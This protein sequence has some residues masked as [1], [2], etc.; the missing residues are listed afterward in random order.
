MID[1]RWD[2][3]VTG[4]RPSATASKSSALRSSSPIGRVVVSQRKQ[5]DLLGDA[6]IGDTPQANSDREQFQDSFKPEQDWKPDYTV[7]PERP[8][9]EYNWA[10]SGTHVSVSNDEHDYQFSAMGWND[11]SRPHAYGKVELHYKWEVWWH[12]Y[13]TNMSL[14]MVESRLRRYTRD[15]G[16][17]WGG[18]LD[19]EGVPMESRALKQASVEGIGEINPGLKDWKNNE[20]AGMEMFDNPAE[21]QTD[22]PFYG[23]SD[24]DD[25][26]MSPDDA[27]T[28]DECGA[29]MLNYDDWRKHV[30]RFHVNPDRKPPREPQPVVDLDDVLPANFNEAI[31]DKTV[32]RQSRLIFQL[33]AS[34]SRP[35]QIPGP[36]P[37]IYDIESDRIYVGH[38]GERHSDIKGR[39]TPGG[40]I[41][42]V[43][44]PKGSV[45]IRT[46]TDMPYT[47]RHMAELWYAM[48]PELQIKSIYLLVGEKRFKLASSNIGHKVR[49]IAASDPAAWAAFKALE[50]LGN[51]YVVGGAVRDIVRGQTPKDVDLM[52]QG[53][54]AEDV[55]D[56]LKG[57]PGRVDFTG[58]QF[59]VF[60]YRDREGNEV[61]IALPRTERSTGPGH[62]DFE[63]ATDPY[64]SVGQD[65][66]RRDFTGNAMAV[67]LATGD[68]V[69]PYHGSEDLKSGVLRTVSDRSFLEDPL[70]ILR[71]FGSVSRH[72]L[73][74]SPDTY[75]DLAA[76][77]HL[78]GEL[79]KER[80]Q[81]ELD[82][83]MGGD[84][85]AK[86]ID[87]MEATGVLQHA[88][89]EVA[90]T[91]GF[92][93]KSKYHAHLLSDHIKLVLRLTA[94]Q[95]KDVDVRWAALLHD[96][97]KP[98][99]QWFDDEGYG[100]YYLNEKGE[101]HDHETLGAEMAEKLLT[102]LR[103][104]NDRIARIVHLV[105]H[106]MFPPFSAPNGARKFLNKVGD[107][108]ADDLM[109]IR[110]ADSGGKDS[111]NPQDGSV[112]QMTQLIDNVR[113]AREPTN[114]AALAINGNDLI[115][116][117]HKPG[118]QMGALLKHLVDL[119]L[120][121]PSLNNRETLLQLASQ[122]AVPAENAVPATSPREA[123]L[124]KTADLIDSLARQSDRAL[125]EAYGYGTAKPGEYGWECNVASAR[126]VLKLMEKGVTDIEKLADESHEGWAEA[127]RQWKD[128]GEKRE[129]RMKLADTPY[130]DL[131]E[132][133]KEKDRVAAR[134]LLDY[135]RSNVLNEK[136]SNILD[137]IKDELDP[138]VFNQPDAMAPTVKPKIVNWVKNKIY[139]TM[140][141][142]GWPDPS[143]YLSL[144]LTGSLTTYQWSAESDFDT[145]LWID[146]ER[147]PEWVRADLIALMI[148]QCDGTI[149]PGTTHPIQCFVVDSTRFTKQDLYEP[150]L[151]SGYDLDKGDWLVMPEKDRNI[152]VSKRWPE[153]LAYARMC[154][155][156]MKMM[157]RYDKYAVAT[158]WHFL[159]RQR[160][161]DMRAGHGDYALSNIV[162]KMLANEGLFPYISEVTGEH[163]A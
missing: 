29:P 57:L 67:N 103:F 113:S 107:E 49:N 53:V 56:A 135:Y 33:T 58:K 137:P 75:H 64:I 38:P 159:H 112:S 97:G 106:H 77:A 100:H 16:W 5:S 43:Y 143:K 50:P 125:D 28:C 110:W 151:R 81:A 114:V 8:A 2:R 124:R 139:K 34:P 80:L 12:V 82:K 126:R 122:S 163:I 45:Q 17:D 158:Y 9:D 127:T 147:F 88:L 66:A 128:H 73:D 104:P 130:S 55:E 111:G 160:F 108:H 19:E 20:W 132:D 70:R 40:I 54:E 145:S 72:G 148:E 25:G 98:G 157:L 24:S 52:V 26:D 62:R 13:Y 22:T 65:L 74:P 44:D 120:E 121:D 117:G 1:P 10:L 156:K 46:D 92:D 142:A 23:F 7:A 48:H 14:H 96:I 118:P 119:V 35:P 39:F 3:Q 61:E 141:D 154:V 90:A 15:Q 140:I 30:L 149:V 95:T 131:P 71:A 36:M 6:Y 4:Q 144:V 102:E 136:T 86:A 94:Q 129:K 78:L 105:Q 146:V 87:L 91:T 76:H 31:M 101:G 79:P 152:D 138:D 59:G 27:R 109:K 11:L 83:L 99:S 162:Y 89:P 155:D 153:H 21:H 133:E 51:V 115:Q 68:L 93:Q 85:P 32:Q 42:G 47:V 37:F 150:G 84:D 116:A 69:D 123:N 134:A 63:V 41:E 18:I 161:L 60:R